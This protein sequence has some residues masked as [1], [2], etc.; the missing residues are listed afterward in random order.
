[1]RE[2]WALA[3]RAGL[4]LVT[5]GACTRHDRD[6]M[7]SLASPRSHVC[8]PQTSAYH[9]AEFGY[10]KITFAN[11]THAHFEWLRNVDGEGVVTDDTWVINRIPALVSK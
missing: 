1:M 7:L 5:L 10:S 4:K 6:V 8:A 2:P 3:A 11:D 9:S